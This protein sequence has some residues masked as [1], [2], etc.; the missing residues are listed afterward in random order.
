[1]KFLIILIVVQLFV[2]IF[3]IANQYDILKNG[4]EVKFE[5]KP[6]DPYDAYRGRYVSIW[7]DRNTQQKGVYGLLSVDENG[8]AKVES[9]QDTKPESG[10]Y[11][12]S[13]DKKYYRLPIDRYYMDE[14][15]APKA[16]RIT[17]STSKVQKT[18]VT[19]RIKNG[20]CVVSG[21]YVDDEKIEEYVKRAS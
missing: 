10:L 16:E 5:T 14:K 6:V 17:Q 2:P 9:I 12:K 4:E 3:M 18:Y 7:V 1:M 20:K 19:V 21:L 8:F 13:K 15:L 11:I